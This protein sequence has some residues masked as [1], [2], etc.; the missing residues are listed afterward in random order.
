MSPRLLQI[1]FFNYAFYLKIDQQAG[2][3]SVRTFSCDKIGE[4]SFAADRFLGF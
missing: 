4:C 2:S 3:A 1:F